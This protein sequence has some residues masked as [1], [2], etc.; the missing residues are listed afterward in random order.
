MSREEEDRIMAKLDAMRAETKKDFETLH[1][2]INQMLMTGCSKASTHDASVT[3]LS[4]RVMEL[5]AYINQAK[6]ATKL[7]YALSSVIGACAAI[8]A[9]YIWK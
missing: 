9:H 3:D 5:E 6:G 4:K 2:R 8:V 1:G 7:G